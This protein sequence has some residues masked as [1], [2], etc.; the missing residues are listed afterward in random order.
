MVTS[1]ERAKE[2]TGSTV[3][4]LLTNV[5]SVTAA[6]DSTVTLK[7]KRPDS[8]LDAR[9]ATFAG[10][11]VNPAALQGDQLDAKATNAGSGPYRVTEFKPNE[12]VTY[13]PAEEPW[14][15]ETGLLK[16]LTITAIPQSSARMAA[17]RSG[18]VDAVILKQDQ[19]TE[20]T[21][22]AS[23][24]QYVLRT[25][26]SPLH[27]ALLLQ[28]DRSEFSNPKVRQA[29]SHAI[30]RATISEQLLNG[31]CT[32]T[33]QPWPTGV[34]GHDDALTDA[35]PFDTAKAKSLLAEAALPKGF[36]FDAYVN[37]GLSPQT[38]IA[39]I[40]QAELKE[41]GIT[42]NITPKESVEATTEFRARNVDA[43]VH[44]VNGE[45]DPSL[46]IDNYLTG[47]M[48]LAAEDSGLKQL[49]DEGVAPK[50][51]R[52]A[53]YQEISKLH[54]EQQ[55]Y[56]PICHQPTMWLFPQSVT[57]DEPLAMAWSGMF[58]PRYLAQTETP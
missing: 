21:E 29:M 42:M 49:A 16:K 40:L 54:S 8:A 58:D 33:S 5:S 27:Y 25:Y 12:S 22:I 7:L 10:A 30:D 55:W 47:G 52:K 39:Q 32:P 46:T 28:T 23:K 15:D 26:D 11:V 44:V 31:D 4:S 20:A 35:Y 17:L 6:G 24:G 57:G 51:D 36:S 1:L 53:K 50:A 2:L 34:L 38:E 45:S 56:L 3:A 43:Y 14:Q 37:N 19:K 48:G 18:A 41:V 13:A 9:L